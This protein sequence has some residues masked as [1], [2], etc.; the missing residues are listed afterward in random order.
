M[1]LLALA[2]A[3]LLA[4]LAGTLAVNGV[5]D[6][7][8]PGLATRL[9]LALSTNV[10]RIEPGSPFP[11]LRARDYPLEPAAL[12]AAARAACEALGWTVEPALLRFRDD[13][14]LRV[15]EGGAP[16]TARL[17]GESRSRVGRGDLGAN[18]RHLRRLLA[19]LDAALAR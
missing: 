13:L 15:L 12:A 3:A 8:E 17:E 9:R 10:A 18:A 14:R 4:A 6:P 11:A 1:M 5:L 2:L 19:E 7:G 16:G